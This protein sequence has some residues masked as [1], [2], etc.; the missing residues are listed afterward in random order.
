MH[1]FLY[2]LQSAISLIPRCISKLQIC[3]CT[4]FCTLIWKFCR[5]L[6]LGVSNILFFE[7]ADTLSRKVIVWKT[8]IVRLHC[9][10]EPH[11]ASRLPKLHFWTNL[12]KVVTFMC[13]WAGNIANAWLPYT[14]IWKCHN[15]NSKVYVLTHSECPCKPKYSQFPH[16]LFLLFLLCV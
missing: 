12:V 13:A 6:L 5:K 11:N 10:M 15:F 9:I 1:G 2:K 8:Y 7:Q 16:E 3:R 14:N 4:P